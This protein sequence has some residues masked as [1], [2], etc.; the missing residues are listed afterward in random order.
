MVMGGDGSESNGHGRSVTG[1]GLQQLERDAM[2]LALVNAGVPVKV[3]DRPTGID[4]SDTDT[5]GN[6]NGYSDGYSDGYSETQ[7]IRRVTK[8]ELG[9]AL[10]DN[11]T[12]FVLGAIGTIE[13]G[14]IAGYAQWYLKPLFMEQLEHNYHNRAWMNPDFCGTAYYTKVMTEAKKI[15]SD[16]T[17]VKV[18]AVGF[19]IISLI[20]FGYTIYT[21][22]QLYKSYEDYHG[23]TTT[24]PRVNHDGTY[25]VRRVTVTLKP[26]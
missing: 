17:V 11:A 13:N 22:Y 21:G 3:T 1:D 10:N 6:G 4:R 7:P 5:H 16:I 8:E 9:R 12:K 18:S 14:F 23:Y 19:L 25:D 15:R 26:V 24:E 2:N 20:S